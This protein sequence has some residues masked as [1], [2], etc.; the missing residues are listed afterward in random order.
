MATGALNLPTLVQKIRLDADTKGAEGEVKSGLDRVGGA[1]VGVGKKATLG[2]TVPI[3]AFGAAGL[4]SASQV[5]TGLREVNTLFGLTGKAAEQ[6]FGELQDLVQGLSADVGIAQD[7]LTQGLYNAISAGVPKDNAFEFMQIAS[8]ASVAGVTDV[9]TAVDG[10]T[11][12]INAFGLDMSDAEGVADSMFAAVQGGKT[13]FEELSASIFNI[14]PAAAAS[15]VS[16]Q[17]VNA[18]I[19][20]LT[21]SG[22]PTAVATTQLRA[23]LTGLQRPSEDLDKAFQKVG[24]ASA[25]A[26]LEEKG[27]AFALGV[28]K[29]ASQ[30]NNGTLT[31]LLGSVEAV[32]AANV[33]AGTSVDKMTSEME[34]QANAAGATET[35]FTEMEKSNSRKME[36]LKVT[37]QNISIAIGNALLPVAGAIADK[38]QIIADGFSK[39]S[40]EMQKVA[41]IALAVTAAAGPMLIIFGKLAQAFSAVKALMAAG[42]I[43]GLGPAI[44]I[45]AAVAAGGFLIYKNWDKVKPVLESVAGVAKQLFDILFRGDFK[46]GPLA[47]DSKIVDQ[48]FKLRDAAFEAAAIAKQLFDVLF[49]GDF[50]GGPLSEDSP[51]ID[52]AFKIRDAAF[53]AADVF[54]TDVLPILE[55]VAG[56]IKDNA[57]PILIGL[58]VVIAGLVAPI[59]TSVAAFVLAYQKIETFR[60]VVNSVVSFIVGTVV[61][62]LVNFASAV[63]ENVG[64]LI[65]YFQKI[66]PDVKEALGHVVAVIQVVM[67][68]VRTIIETVLGVVA[69]LWRAWGDDIWSIVQAIFKGIQEFINATLD[70]I[71]GIIQTVLAVIN[72]DWGKAWDGVLTILRGVWDA[73]FGVIRAAASTIASLLGGIV[74]TFGEVFRPVGN[75]LHTWVVT[76]I[77]NL[78]GFISK[79]P[80][81][82]SS[83][84]SGAFNGLREAFKSAVNFIIQGWNR[85]EFKIPGFDPPG[86]GP[87]FSGFTIGTPKIRELAL[88]GRSVAGQPF[89]AGEGGRTELVDPGFS[90]SAQVLNANRTE[91][92]L[93]Q[94]AGNGAGGQAGNLFQAKIETVDRRSGE[95][96]GRDLAWGWAS[97]QGQPLDYESAGV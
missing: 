58:G 22:T 86:P 36:R 37:F 13:T 47:E 11:S 78:V 69:A 92:L 76:P 91:R 63:A 73:M 75:F 44:P 67:G 23:A 96:L 3:V 62:A 31:E 82:I 81:R 34:R 19:A 95:Q 88:G 85:L 2:L 93:R 12:I 80:G 7:V 42:G 50:K 21:A 35:A 1:M 9:N 45:I 55:K 16:M 41:G 27:L 18:A 77:E 8:K 15:K 51:V 48:A 89:I 30:G 57:K 52:G 60:N 68:I 46:G 40:P 10:L 4:K 79:L 70:V 24:F 54:K 49:K 38:L 43:L 29:D 26:A 84:A 87:K 94:I 6:N 72:G 33:I 90:G 83:A 14:A 32:S 66:A 56:F 74:S 59:A 65:A 71:R 5:E 20:T 53:K 61:P 25:Q 97:A 39:L 28:V 64:K 17:E